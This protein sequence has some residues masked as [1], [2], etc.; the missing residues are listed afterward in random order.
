MFWNLSDLVQWNRGR[1]GSYCRYFTK[2]WELFHRILPSCLSWQD[3]LNNSIQSIS[4]VSGNPWQDRCL[5][6]I[7]CMGDVRLR[8]KAL[9]AIV[10]RSHLPW[11]LAL[12]NAVQLQFQTC[13]DLELWVFCWDYIL[14]LKMQNPGDV[15][16]LLCKSV[17]F[18]A[19]CPRH[20][21]NKWYLSRSYVS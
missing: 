6:I 14:G 1:V 16:N 5:V 20:F 8:C 18:V 7:S 13:T 3:I 10:K 11:S 12:T 2:F 15:S 17:L 9:I 19:T 21:V 4:N